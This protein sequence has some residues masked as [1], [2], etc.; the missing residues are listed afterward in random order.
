[1]RAMDTNPDKSDE[2]GNAWFKAEKQAE[3]YRN[4]LPAKKADWTPLQVQRM[5]SL[6]ATAATRLSA[7]TRYKPPQQRRFGTDF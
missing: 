3:E 4:T 7:F 6:R 1:M 2:L 5:D